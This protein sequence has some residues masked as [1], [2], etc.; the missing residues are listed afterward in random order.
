M[1]RDHQEMVLVGVEEGGG[2][3]E[4][5]NQV[6]PPIYYQPLPLSFV[7]RN[8]SLYIYIYIFSEHGSEQQSS[9]NDD[10]DDI[11]DDDFGGAANKDNDLDMAEFAA[12]TL[13]FSSQ[14]R[15]AQGN[16]AVHEETDTMEELL[17]EQNAERGV[18]KPVAGGASAS[19]EDGNEEVP[20]WAEEDVSQSANQIAPTS[21]AATIDKNNS[22][23]NQRGRNLLMEVKCCVG[24]HI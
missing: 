14:S 21:T 10:K 12:A 6:P 13:R 5:V 2:G 20:S 22:G 1:I 9:R 17:R 16:G 7:L 24:V 3:V 19:L 15:R 23:G 4:G 11:W 18:S 8:M